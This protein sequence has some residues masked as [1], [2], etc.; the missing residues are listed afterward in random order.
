NCARVQDP[1]TLR[2]APQ[3]FGAIR[4]AIDFCANV[5]ERELGAVTDN[6][7]VFPEDGGVLS[8]G[9]FH[10]QPLAL[11]LDMLAFALTQLASFAERRIYS[12][13]G[14]NDWDE[15]GA[16][17]FLTPN[18]RLN[19][20]FMIAQYVAA[21]LVN[22]IKIMA[23]PASIDSIPTSAGMEDFVSMGVTSANKLLHIIEQTQQVVAIEL[24]CAAQILE[25]RKPLK[26]G[27]GV[28]QAYELV[29]S[30]VSILEHDRVLSPDIATMS[31][32][33]KAGAV[34]VL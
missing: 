9:N 16:P 20:G 13:M 30:Y 7:L 6:P 11:A 8:G 24:L 26:P 14:P 34:T 3:V 1:Y 10:G 5:F 21:T 19:S 23:H 17:L 25:F 18:P 31:R 32:A 15:N 22:E 2:C 12:L 33:V 4:D 28:Q 29:R 27:V